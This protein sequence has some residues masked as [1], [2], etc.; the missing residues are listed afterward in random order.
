MAC[1]VV[2]AKA[3]HDRLELQRRVRE[4]D[5]LGL[6]LPDQPSPYE[7]EAGVPEP[8][9][10]AIFVLPEDSPIHSTIAVGADL[11]FYSAEL[12]TAKPGPSGATVLTALLEGRDDVSRSEL[13]RHWAEHIPLAL[14]IHRGMVSY[15]HYRFL[16]VNPPEAHFYVGLA[17]L[18]FDSP[19]DILTGLFTSA[20]DVK[21]VEED[22]A[23][24][25][26]AA[27]VLYTTEH[28]PRGAR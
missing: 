18:G 7:P 27:H 28:A 24:F 12:V 2:L 23:E 20:E 14:E 17:L 9:Y 6:W 5:H 13:M 19:Q 21:R 8:L 26:K 22:V 15:R 16:S 3:K 25:G 10:D 1:T 11:S 4:I